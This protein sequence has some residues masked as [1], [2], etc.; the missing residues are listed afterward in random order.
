LQSKS[1]ESIV[2]IRAVEKEKGRAEQ[3]P[4]QSNKYFLSGFQ[5]YT[6]TMPSFRG[7]ECKINN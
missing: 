5:G 6:N 7:C 2:E 4:T 1:K 3:N